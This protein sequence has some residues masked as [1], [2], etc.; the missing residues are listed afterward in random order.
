MNEPEGLGLEREQAAAYLCISGFKWFSTFS[1]LF[2]GVVVGVVGGL[3]NTARAI[4]K[5][6]GSGSCVSL[7]F[8]C[9]CYRFQGGKQL[10][11]F[12]LLPLKNK[13]ISKAKS[14]VLFTRHIVYFSKVLVSS[15]WSVVCVGVWW[16]VDNP[17]H[18]DPQI[19]AVE[20]P[21]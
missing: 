4:K 13:L 11:D 9:S 6:I 5:Q 17:D 8:Y 16:R 18:A 1:F 19:R 20:R 2:F 12:W 14:N 10:F 15:L 3:D 21:F 7:V